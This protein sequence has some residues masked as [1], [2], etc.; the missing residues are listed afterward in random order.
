MLLKKGAKIIA[1]DSKAISNT[2]I[3]FR[4]KIQYTN[5]IRE[6]MKNTECAIIMTTAKEYSQIN[7]NEL[8]LMKKRL[9]IDSRRLLINRNLDVDYSAIGM[10]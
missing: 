3:I 8:K 6:A 7:N 5:S 1:H 2:K 9:I 4:E 10:G